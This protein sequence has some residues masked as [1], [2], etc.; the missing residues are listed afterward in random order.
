[1]HNQRK[2]KDQ[3]RTKKEKKIQK[4]INVAPF[5]KKVAPGKS[6]KINTHNPTFIPDSRV[7]TFLT[8]YK[9][10]LVTLQKTCQN[11]KV[12]KIWIVNSTTYVLSKFLVT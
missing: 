4:I 2:E 6:T 9:Y 1:M 12:K 10:P 5:N 3:K 8:K 7:V 11:T